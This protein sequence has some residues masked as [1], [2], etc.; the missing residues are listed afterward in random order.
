V[1]Y[2]SANFEPVPSTGFNENVANTIFGVVAAVVYAV[3]QSLL[4]RYAEIP[5]I[6]TQFIC[7]FASSMYRIVAY[8]RSSASS[9]ACQFASSR[10]LHYS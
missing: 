7:K 2:R 1:Q 5:A 4:G 9:A 3:V 6:S 8:L 10:L